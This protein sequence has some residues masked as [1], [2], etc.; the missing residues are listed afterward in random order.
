MGQPY[1]F[2]GKSIPTFVTTK[3]NGS[4]TTKSLT[5]MLQYMEQL[6]AFDRSDGV[7]P[8]VI[9]DGHNSRFGSEYLDYCNDEQHFWTP[10][11]GVPYATNLWKVG[12][13]PQQNGAFKIEPSR[14]K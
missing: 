11:L 4:I 13:S 8:I 3:E 5:D 2:N 9:F 12:D 14:W 6:E 1:I 10:M 7:P